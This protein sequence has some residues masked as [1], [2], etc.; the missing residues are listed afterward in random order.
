MTRSTALHNGMAYT[1]IGNPPLTER[2]AAPRR[3]GP[4][5]YR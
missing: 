5:V 3:N 2:G 4:P 1:H